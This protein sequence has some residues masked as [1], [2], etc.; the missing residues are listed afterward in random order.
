MAGFACAGN[1]IVDIVQTIDAWPGKSELVRIRHEVS[2]VGGGAA[3]VILDLAAFGV[4]VPLYAVGLVG[5]DAHAA[6][7]REACAAAGVD[8]RW[9]KTHPTEMTAHTQVMNVP[10]DSR[11][12]FY[13]AGCNDALTEADIPVEEI[14]AAG[15]RIF[16]LGYP[17]LLAGL[18]R[19]EGG[20]SGAARVLARARAAGMATVVDLVSTAN[21]DFAEVVGAALPHVD[22]L[23]LNEIE[24]G[25]GLGLA[26][27]DPTDR[28]G[29]ETA[30]RRLQ[31]LGPRRVVLH[32]GSGA[33]WLQGSALWAEP[34]RLAASEIVSPV[35][36]GDAFCAGA[37][38]GIHEGWAPEACLRLAHR[39]AAASMRGATASAAIPPLDMLLR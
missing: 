35:G 15:V 16:Y 4:G 6:I 29:L 34:E 33:L 5:R 30:A 19:V 32:T 24:A 25:R 26:P 12:F 21:A 31:A 2:G 14:A 13:H 10:G 36:A 8:A 17:N 11:T 27:L 28:P 38:W 37:L 39:A 20:T 22:T 9:L 23:F 1:W 3:N 18:D 7:C